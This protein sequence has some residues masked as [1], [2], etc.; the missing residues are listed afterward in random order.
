VPATRDPDLPAGGSSRIA[1]SLTPE[2]ATL[3]DEFVWLLE[4]TSGFIAGRVITAME[5]YRDVLLPPF[6]GSRRL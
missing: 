6:A 2:V 4:D 5:R 1:G 3:S